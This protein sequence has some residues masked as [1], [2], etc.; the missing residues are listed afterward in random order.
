MHERNGENQTRTE[1]YVNERA[2][3]KISISHMLAPFSQVSVLLSCT[4]QDQ[5]G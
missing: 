4:V 5:E 3:A 2:R 1:Q